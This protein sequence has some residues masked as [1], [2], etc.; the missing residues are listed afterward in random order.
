SPEALR[1]LS[2]SR[3]QVCLIPLAAAL[4]LTQAGRLRLIAITNPEAA[5]IAP[6]VPTASSSGHPELEMQ[7][8]LGFFAP[9]SIS[10][11]LQQQISGDF[12]AIANDP[13]IHDRLDKAG[14]IAR[15]STSSDFAQYL[16]K[17][18]EHWG[19][20]ARSQKIEPAGVSEL[21]K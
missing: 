17:Q 12:Q 20:I 7:G 13:E 9:K 6:G 1:D 21:G 16:G 5:P 2:E 19:R 14:L 18:L 8:V 3:I 4:P 11:S 15:G 10:D